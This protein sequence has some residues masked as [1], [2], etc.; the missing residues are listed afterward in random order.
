MEGGV[1]GSLTCLGGEAPE[2]P[3]LGGEAPQIG[4]LAGESMNTTWG[5]CGNVM[6][7][8]LAILDMTSIYRQWI[9]ELL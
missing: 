5:W 8:S 1:G 6:G 7:A 9:P 3:C 2:G 4:L